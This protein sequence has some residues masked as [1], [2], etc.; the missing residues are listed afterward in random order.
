M[1]SAY[2]VI[3][4]GVEESLTL[5][6]TTVRD[7]STSLDMTNTKTADKIIIALDVAAKEKALG[8]VEQLRDE[9]SF[10]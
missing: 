4:T 10:F 8:L 1:S 3:P 9:I 5:K 6:R 2:F 7:V